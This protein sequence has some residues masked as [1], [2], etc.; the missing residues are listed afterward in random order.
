M[1]AF[2]CQFVRTDIR[3][4]EMRSPAAKAAGLLIMCLYLFSERFGPR[5][6]RLVSYSHIS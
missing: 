1:V 4:G 3:N 6:M 5:G 2:V